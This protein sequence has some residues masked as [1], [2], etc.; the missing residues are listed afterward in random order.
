MP[1]AKPQTDSKALTPEKQLVSAVRLLHE[2]VQSSGQQVLVDPDARPS[3][4]MVYTNGVTLWMLILQ[5]LGGGKTLGEVVSQV[6]THDR[7]LLPDNK[8]VREN[9][10]SENSAAYARGRQR[11]PLDTVHQFSECV[12]NYLGEISEPILGSQRV[13]ILDGTTITLP[14]TPALRAAYPPASNQY[15]ESVWPVA[16]WMVA[17]EMQS[18]CAL[19]PQ[20]DP[21]YGEHNVSEAEQAQRIVKQLPAHSIV[22][23]DS[24]SG[25]AVPPPGA[26]ARQDPAASPE[27]QRCLDDVEGPAVAAA[28]VQCRAMAGALRRSPVPRLAEEA[29][30]A[31]VTED[32]SPAS[33]SPASQVHQVRKKPTPEKET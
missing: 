16:M 9:T 18:G 20:E 33:P 12:C 31:Q 5:R 13:F 10:L 1:P 17:N 22:M 8:R 24:K 7:H 28:G 25:G 27:L 26:R 32:L 23:A 2:I 6:L 15:G 14:P 4:R 29:S 3:T 30:P 21:M 19:L 11:L